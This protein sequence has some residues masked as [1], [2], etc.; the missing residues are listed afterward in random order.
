MNLTF[1]LELNQEKNY[2]NLRQ[3]VIDIFINEVPNCPL[4]IFFPAS[5]IPHLPIFVGLFP[6]S[7]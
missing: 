2:E 5:K 4:E 3:S 1:I 6:N 7:L